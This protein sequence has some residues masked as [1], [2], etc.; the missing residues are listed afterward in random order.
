MGISSLR[1]TEYYIS[2]DKCGYCDNIVSEIENVHTKQK[3][4]KKLGFH[5][6]KNGRILCDY[7]FKERDRK[8]VD[9]NE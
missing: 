4:L 7:C 1:I 6:I 9:N 2:C 5:K 3:A 8:V